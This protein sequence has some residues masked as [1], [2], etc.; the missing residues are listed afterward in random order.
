[1]YDVHAHFYCYLAERGEEEKRSS[2]EQ[3]QKQKQNGKL[4]KAKE[5][6]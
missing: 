5:A 6:K 1:M 3:K 2:P 4:N